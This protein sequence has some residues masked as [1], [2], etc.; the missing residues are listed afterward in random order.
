MNDTGRIGGPVTMLSGRISRIDL[1]RARR[2]VGEGGWI[3]A[4]QVASVLGALVL[5][6]VLTEYLEPAEYGR[7]SLTLTLGVLVCQAAFAGSVPGVMRYY[8][9]AAEQGKAGVYFHASRQMLLYAVGIALSL[10]GLL[11][12]ALVVWGRT[13]LF[14]LTLLTVLFSVLS[15]LNSTQ[16]M[17]QNAARQRQV[18]ALHGGLESWLKVAFAALLVVWLGAAAEVV[19]FGYILSVLVVFASQVF[20][21]RRLIP[22]QPASVA[23][24]SEWRR[25]IWD[26][27]QP[28][29]L[30]NVFTWMQASSDRWALG[31]LVGTAEVGLYATLLQLGYAPI[32]MLTGMATTLIGPILFG[33]SGDAQ[34]AVRNQ[35]VLR[36]SWR[37]TNLVLSL[38][39]FGFA[40]TW[41]LHPLIFRFLVAEEYRA[42]SYLLPWMVLAGGL[43]AGGQVLVLKMMSDLETHAMVWAKVLT[44]LLGVAF[45]FVGAYIAGL[46]GVVVGMV[47]FSLAHFL[48]LAALTLRPGKPADK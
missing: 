16:S 15:S 14:W 29:V 47:G 31:M 21:I 43:F 38:T 33:R 45:G 48:W 9:L 12:I 20:F 25:R 6:R 19:V 40:F 39:A 44:A 1:K 30:F 23:E 24:H 4:G 8:T 41:F 17:I 35:G 27:S 36:L 22:R 7:L 10:G 26:Y 13:D 37:L 34:D 5:V 18:V 3:I 11:L 32:S 46:T 28:F 42:I 2:L